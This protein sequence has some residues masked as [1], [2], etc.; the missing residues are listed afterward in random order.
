M[1]GESAP[2]RMEPARAT[3]FAAKISWSSGCR[4]S[5]R[6]STLPGRVHSPAGSIHCSGFFRLPGL[7]QHFLHDPA[8]VLF[9]VLL[10]V[11]AKWRTAPGG[12][13]VLFVSQPRIDEPVNAPPGFL[14]GWV[15]HAPGI[16]SVELLFDVHR[17]VEA[18]K[19][20]GIGGVDGVRLPVIE[21]KCGYRLFFRRAGLIDTSELPAAFFLAGLFT[22]PGLLLQPQLRLLFGVIFRRGWIGLVPGFLYLRGMYPDSWV[23]R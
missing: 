22:G 11:P 20:V 12:P 23:I 9:H 2:G 10:P 16:H 21:G 1:P 18:C 17:W 19:F 14:F 6:R 3:R 13:F 4:N 7:F 15:G 5:A 8:I